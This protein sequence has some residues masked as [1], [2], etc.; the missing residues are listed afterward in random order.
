MT[1][2][3]EQIIKRFDNCGNK[4]KPIINKFTFEK[5]KIFPNIE[6]N[7]KEEFQ[8]NTL[9]KNRNR[10][11]KYSI[12]NLGNVEIL[13]DNK[14]EYVPANIINNA[15]KGNGWLV[16]EKHPSVYVYQLVAETWLKK[17]DYSKG[18]QVHHINNDGYDN[19]PENLIYLKAEVHRQ[20]PKNISCPDVQSE[21]F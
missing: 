6:S 13:E 7:N 12:S 19:R 18:W 8:E 1:E 3:Y 17:P 9:R 4:L 14:K 10:K 5:L 16:L 15:D 2:E 20:L 11:L 21:F